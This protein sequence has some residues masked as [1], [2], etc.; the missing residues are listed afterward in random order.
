MSNLL[1][2]RTINDSLK[3]FDPQLVKYVRSQFEMH[4]LVASLLRD[5]TDNVSEISEHIKNIISRTSHIN[6]KYEIN[7]IVDLLLQEYAVLKKD[8][9]VYLVND[10][11][12]IETKI[13]ESKD[14][15]HTG[16][17]EVKLSPKFMVKFM[18]DRQ[19]ATRM[20]SLY[21]KYKR[22]GQDK[23]AFS[24]LFDI[25]KLT[26]NIHSKLKE[27]G[28]EVD[29]SVE[30]SMTSSIVFGEESYEGIFQSN[31]YMFHRIELLPQIVAKKV[32]VSGIEKCCIENV[33]Y[34]KTGDI[35][36]YVADIKFIEKLK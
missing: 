3:K 9:G 30:Y 7:N 21:E 5:Y 34:E 4:P 27:S 22:G 31:N 20:L 14:L 2:N 28:V 10:S 15:I 12:L 32:E 13:N 25:D 8:P 36:K 11:G 18:V 23:F 16:D 33:R 35:M 24:H 26:F 17:G 29:C 6:V 1:S 19:Q